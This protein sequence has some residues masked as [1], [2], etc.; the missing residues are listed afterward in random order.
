MP[1]VA[2]LFSI[3]V[4]T[5]QRPALVG[6]AVASVLAQT[7]SSLECIV[8]DDASSTKP[9]LPADDRVRYIRRAVSG[10]PAAARNTGVDAANGTFL[11]FLDDDDRW[12]PHRLELAR[13]SMS[14][15]P[16]GVCWSRFEDERP[17]SKRW[18]QGMVHDE[19]LDTT[20]PHLGGTAIVREAFVP[21]DEQ[22]LAAEDVEWWLRVTAEL[23][24]ATVATFGCVLR[25]REERI[26]SAERWRS[27]RQLLTTHADYFATHPR[28]S[29]F[30]WQRVGSAARDAGEFGIARHAFRRALSAKPSVPAAIGYLSSARHRTPGL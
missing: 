15:A 28:A 18:L 22:F 16:I 4:P 9:A 10:G 12:M 2:A 1:A 30:R 11:T 8:V 7:E 23:A 5:W 6:I 14:E 29:A 24:V 26:T 19:I 17:K 27:N 20:T 21:F 13:H 25:R 3:I